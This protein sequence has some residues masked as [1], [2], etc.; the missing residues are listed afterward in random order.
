MLHF[1]EFTISSSLSA[2]EVDSVG[3]PMRDR[4]PPADGKDDGYY[5]P[6]QTMGALRFVSR[7]VARHREK[8]ALAQKLIEASFQQA[9][10]SERDRILPRMSTDPASPPRSRSG[11]PANAAR[12]STSKVRIME[13]ER[14]PGRPATDRLELK[15]E[16]AIDRDPWKERAPSARPRRS[17]RNGMSQPV[18]HVGAA[19]PAAADDD[20]EATMY[21]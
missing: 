20:E 13:D 18:M 8:K 19:P 11:S 3:P 21:C 9:L 5:T 7:M 16:A 12:T 2:T 15:E 14:E 4:P 6:A 17:P 10:D 1:I